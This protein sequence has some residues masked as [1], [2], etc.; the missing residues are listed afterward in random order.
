MYDPLMQPSIPKS[1]R[2]LFMVQLFSIN[3]LITLKIWVTGRIIS[4][5]EQTLVFKGCYSS[6]M[7]ITYK[8]LVNVF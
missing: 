5:N 4:I 7:W 6:K 3:S 8:C 1:K 2:Q